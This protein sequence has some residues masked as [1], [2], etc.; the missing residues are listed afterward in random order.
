MGKKVWAS[1]S[2][3]GLAICAGGAEDETDPSRG[4]LF[5]DTGIMFGS[6]KELADRLTTMGEKVSSL[7][8]CAHGDPG[9]VD[10]DSVFPSNSSLTG[11]MTSDKEMELKAKCLSNDTFT[12]Y[13]NDLG[14]I[15]SAMEDGG[16]IRFMSCNM[17]SGEPGAKLL[18]RLS[19][20]PWS[21]QYVTGFTRIGSITSKIYMGKC[22]LPGLKFG[23][24]NT[25]PSSSQQQFDARVQAL[26]KEP[27]ADVGSPVAK[28]SR[29]GALIKNPD[30]ADYGN[31]FYGS[32]VFEVGGKSTVIFFEKNE[33]NSDY[34]PCA[35][36]D[37]SSPAVKRHKGQWLRLGGLNY[38]F[39]F[40]KGEEPK[41]EYAG[42]DYI[43]K[44]D[45]AGPTG[46]IMINRAEKG[47]FKIW[48]SR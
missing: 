4:D 41:P 44:L 3:V 9:I 11:A 8:I 42:A 14:R 31:T 17:G 19:S 7:A 22:M 43:F 20:G 40:A 46:R 35:W 36:A 39:S 23:I 30:Q 38:S 34:G 24:D 13:A 45:T 6:L 32:W 28:I 16:G 12:R 47:Q 33:Y 5:W 21:K 37:N 15:G 18:N 1:S 27:W 2:N 25:A 26:V 48:N 29:N 10:I